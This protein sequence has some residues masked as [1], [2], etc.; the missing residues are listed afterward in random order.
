MGCE[1]Q[2]AVSVGNREIATVVQTSGSFNSVSQC[3]HQHMLL[4]KLL[5]ACNG[6]FCEV[7]PGLSYLCL[8]IAI[9]SALQKLSEPQ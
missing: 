1:W 8:N 2:N 9:L 5:H 4:Q 7:T 3:S 6:Q